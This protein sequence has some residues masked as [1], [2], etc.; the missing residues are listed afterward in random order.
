MHADLL[1]TV[2]PAPA[3]NG[4]ASL[5]RPLSQP[6]AALGK[7]LGKLAGIQS[8]ALLHAVEELG[9]ARSEGHTG[10]PPSHLSP[11][12]YQELRQLSVV[13]LP[14]DSRPLVLTEEGSLF[15]LRDF[16]AEQRLAD[17]LLDR[18]HAPN[19]QD[20]PDAQTI[21][22]AVSRFFGDDPDDVFLPLVQSAFEGR[23][24]ILTGGPGTGKTT[25]IAKLLGVLFHLH[26]G[27]RPLN[28]SLAA[29]TGK[30]AARMLE[31]L[32]L[33]AE[34]TPQLA[35]LPA[36]LTSA[37]STIHR[38]L[39]IG[40]AGREP[41]HK[42]GNPLSADVIVIDEASMIPLPLFAQLLDALLPHTRL[43]L[44]GDQ[45]QLPSVEGGCVLADLRAA[46]LSN[47][48]L[49]SRSVHLQVSHRFPAQSAIGR[50][51]AA[52][53]AGDAK[54][55]LDLLAQ[56]ASV[57]EKAR[58]SARLLPDDEASFR[59]DLQQHAVQG[60]Q[61]FLALRSSGTAAQALETLERFRVLCAVR[62]GPYG[63]HTV[64][65]LVED[66]AIPSRE[67][68][69]AHY[70]GRPLLITAN[71]YELQ[72]FNGDTG[73]VWHQAGRGL[74]G[75]FPG[76]AGTPREIPLSQLPPHETAFA[77]T[78][79]K[80]QGS[81]FDDI[82]LLLPDQPLPVLTRELLYTGL[83]RARKGVEW[84]YSPASLTAAVQTPTL[85]H[86]GLRTRLAQG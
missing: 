29:P 1:P 40:G 59:H 30:A 69:G 34:R 77:M 9:K 26:T 19:S 56:P 2:P 13:G 27:P 81:E 60:W 51:S 85:R 53:N 12:H 28:V 55:V 25:T 31:S 20:G 43:F 57:H 39:G 10:L 86:G 78:V 64:N 63:V 76:P 35:D 11:L 32:R 62:E 74:I 33:A 75:C 21:Q 83:T 50:L 72:L 84:W 41:I 14:S 36:R 22:N 18:L 66:K 8:P 7:L 3:G 17:A 54:T 23:L 38:L 82:L 49:K 48:T 16:K 47:P 70:H 71:H 5:E 46:A 68:H 15:F 65:R 4:P 61:E 67:F 79:H 45:D 6:Y 73:V 24:S 44:L 52:V 58:L 42:A 80:S 37:P